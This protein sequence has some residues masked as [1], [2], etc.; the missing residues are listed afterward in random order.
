MC[1]S[2]RV[3]NVGVTAPDLVIGAGVDGFSPQGFPR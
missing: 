2:V 3:E 1:R